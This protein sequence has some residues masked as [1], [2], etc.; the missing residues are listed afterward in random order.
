MKEKCEI[1]DNKLKLFFDKN[2]YSIVAVKRVLSYYTDVFFVRIE[3]K[4]N[5]VI[6][7]LENKNCSEDLLYISKE[8]Y[9]KVLDEDVRY[10]IERETQKVRDLMYEKAMNIVNKE[11]E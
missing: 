5:H 7:W 10:Q 1:E 4:Q 3:E 2:V 6:A 11:C 9:N 8:I